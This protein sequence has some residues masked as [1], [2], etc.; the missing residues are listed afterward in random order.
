MDQIPSGTCASRNSL[1]RNIEVLCIC[2]VLYYVGYKGGIYLLPII[3]NHNKLCFAPEQRSR[4][5]KLSTSVAP[6]M[7]C[8]PLFDFCGSGLWEINKGSKNK[9]IKP[10][11]IFLLAFIEKLP[12]LF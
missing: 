5:S 12:A 2:L 8:L 6:R 10:H 9:I 7:G 4:F 3:T 11:A 1:V